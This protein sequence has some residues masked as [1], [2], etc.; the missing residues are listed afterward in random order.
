MNEEDADITN[1]GFEAISVNPGV[2]FFQSTVSFGMYRGRHMNATILGGMQVSSKGDI[3]NWVI[4][5]KLVKVKL[6]NYLYIYIY[7]YNNF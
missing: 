2:S 7:I 3:A 4:P 5:K 6:I 1:A